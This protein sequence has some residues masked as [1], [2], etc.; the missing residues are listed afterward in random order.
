MS[1]D[2]IHVFYSL[3]IQVVTNQLQLIKLAGQSYAVWGAKSLIHFKINTNVFGNFL[4]YCCLHS[5]N[6]LSII[7]NVQSLHYREQ[8]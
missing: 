1:S 6:S 4:H 3:S 7:C 5:W 8:I 2:N